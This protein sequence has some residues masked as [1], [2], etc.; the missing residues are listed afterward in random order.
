MRADLMN[1]RAVHDHPTAK[2]DGT[3]GHWL[4]MLQRRLPAR[5]RADRAF[6]IDAHGNRS[7]QIDMV[8]HDRQFCPLL[9]D[10]EGCIS[11][12]AESVYAV[13]EVKQ[14]IGAQTLA[15]AGQKAKSV[16]QLHRTSATFPSANGRTR[17]EPKP[18]LAGLVALRS[19]WRKPFA[20]AIQEA[21]LKNTGLSAIDIG[22]ALEGGAFEVECDVAGQRS[23]FTSPAE[24][25]LIVFFLRLLHRLQMLGTVPAIEYHEYT[26]LVAPLPRASKRRGKR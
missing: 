2:G 10:T 8:I 21:A 11:V 20:T 24:S 5:Y 7:E 12:P 16:R 18:I 13:I 3:E 6:V 23:V 4:K 26:S 14:T 15:Y 19:G 1:V 17:T 25:S 9:L 22:C